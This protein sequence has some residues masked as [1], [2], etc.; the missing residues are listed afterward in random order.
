MKFFNE[1]LFDSRIENSGKFYV[2][3]CYYVIGSN[4]PRRSDYFFNN[5]SLRKQ[6][7]GKC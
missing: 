7:K 1:N 2:Q 5:N 6:F 3:T 4:W